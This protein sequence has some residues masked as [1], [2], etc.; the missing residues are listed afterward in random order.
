M[1]QV[2]SRV[3]SA[4][5]F[6]FKVCGSYAA[7]IKALKIID[8][9]EIRLFK[10]LV[11]L[12]ESPYIF[13]YFRILYLNLFEIQFG[14]WNLCSRFQRFGILYAVLFRDGPLDLS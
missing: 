8:S 1:L 13:E 4:N 9:T 14:I 5:A 2:T 10:R 11:W 3:P 7:A 12:K 6:K